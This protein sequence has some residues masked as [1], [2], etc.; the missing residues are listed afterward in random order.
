M[1]DVV[2]TLLQIL[3]LQRDPSALPRN[4]QV[5]VLVAIASVVM[6]LVY[7][8]QPREA[9]MPSGSLIV[10]VSGAVILVY[11]ALLR[12]YGKQDRAMQVMTAMFGVDA[13]ITLSALITFAVL[14]EAA[15]MSA[16]L[17]LLLWSVAVRGKIISDG[18]DWPIYA[19][20]AVEFAILLAAD[21]AYAS[22]L[23]GELISFVSQSL[24]LSWV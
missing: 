16:L 17:L 3:T 18:L 12:L 2:R 8:N 24:A 20:I 7:F 10:F 1:N 4:V 14:G 15:S 22:S 19:G 13:L 9:Q 23:S 5:L 21:A 11:L 6:N